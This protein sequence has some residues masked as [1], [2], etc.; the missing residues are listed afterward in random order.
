MLLND[1]KNSNEALLYPLTFCNLFEQNMD[2][3]LKK[4]TNVTMFAFF[5]FSK[6]NRVFSLAEFMEYWKS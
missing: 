6:K 1:N 5:L 4:I 3:S 2:F